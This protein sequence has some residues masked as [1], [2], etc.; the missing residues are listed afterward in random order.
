MMTI[1]Q[2]RSVMK[3]HHLTALVVAA[4]AAPA[5]AQETYMIDADH[6]V[7]TFEVGHMGITTQRGNFSKTSGKVVLDR[8]AKSG[9]IEVTIDTT[10]VSSGSAK[11]DAMLRS[12]DY[13]DTAKYPTATFKATKLSY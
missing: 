11:R 2:R 7:P 12:E 13:F 10:T 3:C 1:F 9:S 5:L 6:T 4:V 8:A